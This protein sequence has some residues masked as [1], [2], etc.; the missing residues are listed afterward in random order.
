VAHVVTHVAFF[1]AL[2]AHVGL[3]LWRRLLPRML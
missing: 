1:V 2:A 3:V